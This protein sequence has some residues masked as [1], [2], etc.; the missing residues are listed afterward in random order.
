MRSL[1]HDITNPHLQSA[2]NFLNTKWR[3]TA[4]DSFSGNFGHPYTMWTMYQA[5]SMTI[6]LNDRTRIVNLLTDCGA[7]RR[8]SSVPGSGAGSCA[9][10]DDYD[11]WLTE[12]QKSDG[13][14][15]TDSEWA[16]TIST[17][18]YLNIL[19][20]TPIRLSAY[21]CPLNSQSWRDTT[22]SWAVSSLRLGG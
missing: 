3:A 22:D 15:T 16:D 20:G 6:G 17:A 13:S 1:G 12:N 8:G 14:W 19:G 21:V 10:S 9:W 4:G 11:H 5:L 18:L 2:L 7:N